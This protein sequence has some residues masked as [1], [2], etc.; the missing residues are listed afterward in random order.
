M[1]NV[2]HAAHATRHTYSIIKHITWNKYAHLH[3]HQGH[4]HEIFIQD[5][6]YFKLPSLQSIRPADQPMTHDTVPHNL[7][8]RYRRTQVI[9]DGTL[10]FCKCNKEDYLSLFQ[11]DCATHF[12]SYI[13]TRT[14][15][16][17]QDNSSYTSW[18]NMTKRK[19]NHT[20]CMP[21]GLYKTFSIM[22]K[23]KLEGF[24]L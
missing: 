2:N 23:Y 13:Y 8:P 9:R 4:G 6:D 22:T 16:Y 1:P 10:C 14:E 7:F 19:R 21:C 18:Q 11:P 5:T 3:I 12:P 15:V 20:W 17:T 24:T